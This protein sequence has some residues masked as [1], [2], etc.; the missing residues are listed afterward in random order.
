MWQGVPTPTYSFGWQRCDS[1]GNNCVAISGAS[2]SAYTLVGAD[3]GSTLEV[4]VTASNSAGQASATSAPSSVVGAGSSAPSIT[5]LPSL[6]GTATV[7]QLLTASSGVWQGVPTP[8][9]SFGWQRC[10]SGGNNCVAISGASGSAYT[11]V[12]ADAGS[13][14]EVVV[15]ASNSA[16]QASA[17]SAPSSVVLPLVLDNFNR[18]NGG[19]GANW[20]PIGPSGF[21]SMTISGNAA[22]DVSATQYAWDYW[23]PS[24][25]GPNAE[26][27]FTV[28]SYSGTDTIRVGARVTG[29]TSSYSGYFLSVTAGAWSII[30][31]DHGGQ[32]VTLASGVTQTLASGDKLAIQI[33]GSRVT[34]LHYTSASGW[35]QVLSYDTVGDSIRYANPGGLA[36]EF[37]TSTIDD[38]G[39]GTLP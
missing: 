15:T 13:T 9:Y 37:K 18:A 17:T 35:V 2:G 10:D 24:S 38:F 23:K 34:A 39:G 16:G 28:A 8:T 22:V 5:S 20:G 11:L 19:V 14:L 31:V 6:S 7:G 29:G 36:V 32:P 1:G 33:I 25:F 26:A 3:A 27:Y 12:G 4:V 21:A 30:R